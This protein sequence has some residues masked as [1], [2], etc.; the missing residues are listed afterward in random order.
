[1]AGILNYILIHIRS[2]LFSS[3]AFLLMFIIMAKVTDFRFNRRTTVAIFL[4]VWFLRYFGLT[5]YISKYLVGK[6]GEEAW[7]A[8]LLVIAAFLIFL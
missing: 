1:M 7:F 3:L 2:L 6:Y 8:R 4:P 5:L